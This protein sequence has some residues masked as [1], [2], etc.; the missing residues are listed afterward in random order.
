MAVRFSR[1]RKWLAAAGQRDWTA[2]GKKTLIHGFLLARQI[3]PW[4]S[5]RRDASLT[6]AKV[7]GKR[8]LK[9]EPSGVGDTSEQAS[10]YDLNYKRVFRVPGW[11]FN[12]TQR[13]WQP[14]KAREWP[15]HGQH[16]V[17]CCLN[18]SGTDVQEGGHH[19]ASQ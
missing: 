4:V 12:S 13:R 16:T 5:R 15:R 19:V 7:A 17:I 2:T 6:K 9:V 10:D 1:S 18:S 11:C 14:L 3:P 8:S